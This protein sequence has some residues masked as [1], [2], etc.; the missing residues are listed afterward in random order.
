MQMPLR[1]HPGILI[2]S[3][4]IMA[5]LAWGFWP[6]PVMVETT[7]VKRGPLTV[8]IEEEGRTRV[9]DRYVI[10]SPVNGMTCRMH[11]KVGDP[12]SR[13]QELLGITPLDSPVLDARSRAQA[14]AQVLAA[15]SALQAAKEQA[16]AASASAQL[17]D[18]KYKRYQPLIKKGLVSQET[19]DQAKTEAMT[20]TAA[21]RSADFAVEVAK[22]ELKAAQTALEYS[23]G[24]PSLSDEPPSERVPVTS[25]IDGKILKVSRECEGPVTIG[26]SLLEVGD[27]S[28]LE[29]EVDVLSADAVKIKPGMTVL[30]DRWGGPEPLE[31]M[32]RRV[33]PVGFTKV[34]ALGVEEQ[35]VLVISDFTS[36]TEKWQRLGDGY[37]VEA[38]FILWHE[39]DV[40]QIPSNAL[41]RYQGGWAVFT[42]ENGYAKRQTVTIGERNGLTAQILTGLSENQKIISHPSDAVDDGV[43]IKERIS[44]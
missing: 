41:F 40:L 7:V 36:P 20:A 29:V 18:D 8:T 42:V 34:S 13:G 27:P 22:Y 28:A 44:S 16:L 35:R 26:E 38:K 23:A 3:A 43:A 11:L 6:Q 10:S 21:K 12:V 31:G 24:N 25:P 2:V 39:D 9:I 30:F 5:L 32:V 4:V 33:E 19:F 1:N 15:R 37:R 17:A 14:E